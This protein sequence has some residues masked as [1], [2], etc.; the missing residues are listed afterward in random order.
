MSAPNTPRWSSRQAGLAGMLLALSPL[1]FLLP[2]LGTETALLSIQM[3][4]GIAALAALFSVLCALS[5]ERSP[6][7]GRFFGAGAVSAVFAASFA[8][9]R[10]DP[11][12]ALAG[13]TGLIALAAL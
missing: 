10:T 12:V 9:L 8:A 13:A 11:F 2:Y 7:L 6:A 5:M 3:R 1:P 4:L